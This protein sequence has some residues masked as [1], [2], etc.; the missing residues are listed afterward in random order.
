MLSPWLTTTEKHEHTTGEGEREVGGERR[1]EGRRG[2]TIVSGEEQEWI[3][4][5]GRWQQLRGVLQI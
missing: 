2:E 4:Y 5:E 1:G 3:N